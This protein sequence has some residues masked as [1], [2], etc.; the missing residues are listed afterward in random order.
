MSDARRSLDKLV[1]L[2]EENTQ[3]AKLEARTALRKPPAN[4]VRKACSKIIAE[5]EPG[6]L[7]YREK[8][9]QYAS[10]KRG[11]GSLDDGLREQST[12]G[13]EELLAELDRLGESM[14]AFANGF[15]SAEAAK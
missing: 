9:S 13:T 14:D 12:A 6:T 3:D 5:L 10:I 15:P 8:E 7:L 11:L 1:P 2:I 4:G